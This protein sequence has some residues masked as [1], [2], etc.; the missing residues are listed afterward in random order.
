[1]NQPLLA[2]AVLNAINRSGKAVPCRAILDC[3]ATT[4]FIS[5]RCAQ[6]LGIDINRKTGSV[7]GIG[8]N[9]VK[10]VSGCTLNLTSQF[11]ESEKF[12]IH[13]SILPKI[14][15]AYPPLPL[16]I[17]NEIPHEIKLAD[18][19][20][21]RPQQ[22][23]LLLGA[24]IFW[25]LLLD[26]KM[27]IGP[28]LP[29]LRK[30]KL[31]W[32]VS[33]PLPH[34]NSHRALVCA[35]D[36][37][38]LDSF[39]NLDN[40]VKRFWEIDT[41]LPKNNMLSPHDQ[42]CEDH[43]DLHTRRDETGRYIVRLP[44]LSNASSL[45]QS[46]AIAMRRFLNLEKKLNRDLVSKKLYV[47]FINEY[48]QLGHLQELSNFD[49][50]EP[51]YFLP[52]HCVLKPLSSSTKLRVVFDASCKTSTGL[53]LND[54]LHSGP[55]LQDDLFVILLRFRLFRYVLTGDI[56]KM[57]RQV[58]IDARD[59]NFQMILWRSSISESIKILRLETVTYGTAPGS[60]LAIKTLQ[61][62]A[63]DEE[64]NFILGARTLRKSFYVD[65]MMTG[66]NSIEDLRDI[67]TQTSALLQNGGFKMSKFCSNEFSLLELIDEQ[68][69]EKFMSIDEND[70][71]KVLGLIW[72][73]DSDVFHFTHQHI[74]TPSQAITKRTVLS[75]M[76]R[77]FD[78]LG[79]VCPVITLAKIF[80]QDLWK[81]KLSWD[82]EL[83]QEL[84]EK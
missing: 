10:L 3:A 57:F 43:Y 1:M 31:G 21:D 34:K 76:A 72:Q 40:I 78:P 46:I 65:D 38:K 69:R 64:H 56:Q 32:I 12:N 75:D 74:Q 6:M 33:G 53:S 7:G 39:E 50:S 27:D 60:Y 22:I 49:S 15:Y 52:H 37:L 45:G 55:K 73:P 51:H 82:K 67:M 35:E 16:Y 2:T 63:N 54:V 17:G 29:H 44:F 41:L 80:Y 66:S 14:M 79:L 30:T 4:N 23:D 47:D 61:R 58:R 68:Y 11:S 84:S 5:H 81:L 20:F 26:E 62:L 19:G 28:N 83:S 59:S 77:L 9:V 18:P 13:A 36:G 25:E 8:N 24:G 48:Q 71:I 70:V 42:E